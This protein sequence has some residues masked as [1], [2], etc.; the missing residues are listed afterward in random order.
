MSGSRRAPPAPILAVVGALSLGVGAC[1][2]EPP[3]ASIPSG[4][5]FR[6]ADA[7]MIGG[8]HY[9]T[10][11]EGIRTSVLRFD[12]LYSWNDSINSQLR[13]VVL[14][15]FNDDGSERAEVT[16]RNGTVDARFDNFIAQGDVV[17]EVPGQGIRLETE[18]LSYH[19]ASDQIES[20]A[21]FVM[22]R[23]GS[24]PL[25]GN[26]FRSDLG[27]QNITAENSGGCGP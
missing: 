6:Q 12:T 25:R 1:R 3:V 7:V 18:E 24:T 2:E 20:D 10:N 8:E 5:S 27:F 21:C 26:F 22:N 16:A 19:S 17:L 15:I 4:E 11:G 23:E 14:S 13:G 9:F